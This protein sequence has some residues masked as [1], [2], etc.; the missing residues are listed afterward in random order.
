MSGGSEDAT[1]ADANGN[2]PAEDAGFPVYTWWQDVQP[3][4]A[5]K[6]QL[7]HGDPPQFTAPMPLVAY[8]DVFARARQSGAPIHSEMVNRIYAESA[9]MPPPSQPQLT[10]QEKEII[11]AWSFNGA[12][13]GIPP[14]DG[15]PTMDAGV[16]PVEDGGV[17]VGDAGTMT[18]T[19]TAGRSLELRATEPNSNAPYELPIRDTNYVCWSMTVPAGGGAN[20]SVVRFEHIIDNS[21]N[22]HHMLLFKN[23]NKDARPGPFGCGNLP[24]TWDMVSGWA[25]GRLAEDM[26]PGVGVRLAEGD[27]VVLQIHYDDVRRMNTTDHSGIRMITQDV[28]GLTEAGIMWAGGAW[29]SPING[30]NVRRRGTCR[31]RDPVTIFANFPHMHELGIRIMLEL[32][33]QGTNNWVNINEVPAW[34][35]ED[36]PRLPIEA[37]HQQLM[38][39]DEL[40]TTCWWNTQGRSVSFGEATDDEMC[41]NFIYHYPLVSNPT[42]YCAGILN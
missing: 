40:R 16:P 24:L 39:G 3:I 37:V 5:E 29:L 18:P 4:V 31:V 38:P 11:R 42:L 35:F 15:G 28:A 26:P 9:R 2:T 13:E 19:T 25:P 27:Q 17:T 22:L 12:P 14:A 32:K 7:C 1:A 36:Q 10:E 41:F 21:T 8:Q 30:S 34:D 20:E 33:R 23:R 6:C